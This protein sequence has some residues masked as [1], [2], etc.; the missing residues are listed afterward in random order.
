MNDL[1]RFIFGEV[2]PYV[3]C[4]VFGYLTKEYLIKKKQTQEVEK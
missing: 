2:M 3:L 1:Y 4:F